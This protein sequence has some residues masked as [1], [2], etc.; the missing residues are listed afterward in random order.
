MNTLHRLFFA[1]AVSTAWLSHAAAADAH[2]KIPDFSALEDKASESV[3]ITLD[4]ALLDMAA[5]F[6][7]PA[8][9]KDVAARKAINGITGIYVRSFTFDT[10]FE[11][12]TADVD[13]VR[14]QLSGR[15]WQRLVEVRS[16][17][18]Q[19]KVDIYVSVDGKLANGLAIIASEPREFTIVN[20]VGSIDMQKLHDL[21]GQFGVPKL[22]LEKK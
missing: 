16:R 11:Y 21:E 9:P 20:I 22:E 3:S 12:P 13:A 15:G 6:L 14:K 4:P 1:L 7:D 5:R 18:T 8:D 17:K 2:L 10:E 19:S